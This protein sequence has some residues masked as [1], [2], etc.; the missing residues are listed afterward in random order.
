MKKVVDLKIKRQEEHYIQI[1]KSL[2]FGLYSEKLIREDRTITNKWFIVLKDRETGIPLEFTPYTRLLRYTDVTID[3]RRSETIEAWGKF[4][5]MFLN[6]V[7]I[8]SYE[9]FRISDIKEVTIDIGN[10]FLQ[11]YADGV[12]GQKDKNLKTVRASIKNLCKLYSHIKSIYKKDAKEIY[13]YKWKYKDDKNKYH[14][15]NPFNINAERNKQISKEKKS[16]FRS[17]PIDIFEI[18]LRLSEEYYPELTFAIALQAYAGLRPSE[19]CNVRQPIDPRKPGIRYMKVGSKIASMTID[20]GRRYEMREDGLSVGAIKKRRQQKVYTEY[21]DRVQELYKKHLNELSKYT[22]EPGFYPMFVNRD[23]KAITV[24]SYRDKIERLANIYLRKELSKSNVPSHRYYA[25]IL[26][27]RKLSPHFLRHYFTVL[28]V[29]DNLTPHEV[30]IW[31][32]DDLLDTAL[33]YCQNK[34]ELMANI[35]AINAEIIEDILE[36]TDDS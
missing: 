30:A 14:Y 9:L 24:K 15:N 16:I 29:L 6:Y 27:Q 36:D 8:D 1:I 11:D 18:F 17:M 22:L 4:V 20:L 31:R 5:C 21:L 19:V 2:K 3:L 35:R 28:L 23:G 25:E 26:S 32:G 34:E 10:K 12:V 7:L 13:K 33:I